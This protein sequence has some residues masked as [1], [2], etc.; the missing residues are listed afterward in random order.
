MVEPEMIGTQNQRV[1]EY[2]K[3]K[4][5]D[6]EAEV[7]RL[8]QLLNAH[9]DCGTVMKTKLL[10]V[11]C[12]V[13]NPPEPDPCL[14]KVLKGSAPF[15]L[16][17]KCGAQFNNVEYRNEHELMEHPLPWSDPASNPMRDVLEYGKRWADR[18]RRTKI[19]DEPPEEYYT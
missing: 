2:W 17:G 9:H 8:I 1:V 5:E 18:A 13:C 3:R 10:G 16:C 19:V 12:P 6:F 14:P 11:K 15:W 4:A 7:S